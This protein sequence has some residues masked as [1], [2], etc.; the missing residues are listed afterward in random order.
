LFVVV[1][2][3]LLGW[4]LVEKKKKNNNNNNKKTSRRPGFMDHLIRTS[5]V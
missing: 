1:A 3:D 5:R 2:L 4:E